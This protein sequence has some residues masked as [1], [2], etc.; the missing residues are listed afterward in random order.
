MHLCAVAARF[1]DRADIIEMHRDTKLDA[2]SG[3]ALHTARL[4][5]QARERAGQGG[6][7]HPQTE[8][9]TLDGVRGGELGGVGIHSVRLPGLVAHQQVIFGGLGQTLTLRHDTS[10]QES[11]VP[12]TILALRHVVQSREFTE[13]LAALLGLE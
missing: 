8:K 12:G 1:F 11:Y 9:Y 3:T 7:V 5:A 4:M 10:S 13:G 6:L 2:P